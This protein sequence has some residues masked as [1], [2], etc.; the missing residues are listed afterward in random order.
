MI[1][2]C[3]ECKNPISSKADRCPH[4]GAPV[5]KKGF[6]I[7]DLNKI[8]P[9]HSGLFL[10]VMNWA[11]FIGFILFICGAIITLGAYIAYEISSPS[12]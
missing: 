12:Y 6:W 2:K 7:F 10:S 11:T 8:N 3:N 9:N 4:C 1:V 5:E